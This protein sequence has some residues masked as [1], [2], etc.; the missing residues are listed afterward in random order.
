MITIA[1]SKALVFFR[2]EIGCLHGLKLYLFSALG[3][4]EIHCKELYQQSLCQKAQP[5]IEGT[6]ERIMLSLF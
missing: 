3:R 6:E 2:R 1:M 4:Q 5:S